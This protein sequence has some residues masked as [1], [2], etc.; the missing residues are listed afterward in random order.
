[1]T[2][3]IIGVIAAGILLI[4]DREVLWAQPVTTVT[5]T[6]RLYRRFLYGAFAH[7]VTDAV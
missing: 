6:Q 1:M 7:D 3:S 2:Y 5:P 4:I